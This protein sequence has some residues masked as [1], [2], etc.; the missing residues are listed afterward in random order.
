MSAFFR[1]QNGQSGFD[2]ASCATSQPRWTS[3]GS[4][5]V[6]RGPAL[7]QGS[8]P[9]APPLP[10]APPLPLGNLAA[11]TASPPHAFPS[12]RAHLW[13]RTPAGGVTV[14]DLKNLRLEVRLAPSV[15]PLLLR[16]QRL[17]GQQAGSSSSAG[18]APR[19]VAA[20]LLAQ[21][22][23]GG[24]T[25]KGLL[26]VELTA[27]NAAPGVGGAVQLPLAFGPPLPDVAVVQLASALEVAASRAP[28]PA[29]LAHLL[30]AQ[31]SCEPDGCGALT[32]HG[33]AATP[34][35]IL[36]F[37]PLL[38]KRVVPGPLVAR[39]QD[40]LLHSPPAA[41]GTADLDLE[42]GFLTMD[43]GRSLVPLAASDPTAHSMPLVG[44]WVAGSA[45]MRH[46]LVAAACLRFLCSK[47]LC[48]KATAV[49]ASFLLLLYSH[50]SATVPLCFEVHVR[51]EGGLL[52]L[53]AHRFSTAWHPEQP[54]QAA[55]CKAVACPGLALPGCP[56]ALSQR[57]PRRPGS[58]GG[59]GGD[60]SASSSTWLP[61]A[62]GGSSASSSTWL[63]GA[64]GGSSASSSTWLPGDAGAACKLQARPLQ[65]P[66][67][68]GCSMAPA[69]ALHLWHTPPGP[70]LP[71]PASFAQ[72]SPPLLVCAPGGWPDTCAAVP[73]A[74]KALGPDAAAALSAAPQDADR[75][76]ALADRQ[77]AEAAQQAAV[78]VA[79][80]T[81]AAAGSSWQAAK[82]ELGEPRPAARKD[83][84]CRSWPGPAGLPEDS[85]LA[86]AV[87]QACRRQP[88]AATDAAA[89]GPGSPVCD[90]SGTGSTPAQSPLLPPPNVPTSAPGD[91][92]MGGV[93]GD[94]S[95]ANEGD[96]PQS[97]AP[98][99]RCSLDASSL[100]S[101]AAWG[102]SSCE[103]LAPAAH[104][105]LLV[106]QQAHGPAHAGSS[107]GKVGGMP[108]PEAAVL[109]PALPASLPLIAAGWPE[110]Q[111]QAGTAQ[112]AALQQEVHLLRQE[113]ALLRAQ[114]QALQLAPA[115]TAAAALP[116]LQQQLLGAQQARPAW[117][118][119][120]ATA[121]AA[122][123]A[124]A[125]MA[126]RQQQEQEHDVGPWGSSQ[127]SLPASPLPQQ[128]GQPAGREQ[129]AGGMPPGTE[130]GA[131][132]Q[133]ALSIP[134][135][136]AQE[137]EHQLTSVLAAPAACC[138]ASSPV[139]QAAQ[140]MGADTSDLA[141][142][143]MDAEAAIDQLI[144]DAERAASVACCW[145]EQACGGGSDD[146]GNLLTCGELQAPQTLSQPPSPS[147]ELGQTQQQQQQ[148]QAAPHAQQQA[149]HTWQHAEQHGEEQASSTA[150]EAVEASASGGKPAPQLS[151]RSPV[152][153]GAWEGGGGS[154]TE[155]EELERKYGLRP[156]L[157]R[158]GSA[159][160]D[161]RRA[162]QSDDDY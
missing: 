101:L 62:A 152:H 146:G 46:P 24:S 20:S 157:R 60:S 79:A 110:A 18:S 47:A 70:V 97:A 53:Q 141:P 90:S 81:P 51:L 92:I 95:G 19:H 78:E 40:A 88:A 37:K 83:R 59:S 114:V 29:G 106:L 36:D 32:L 80:Q 156:P 4:K 54:A 68:A 121:A 150:A 25:T 139:V 5:D 31:L 2:S 127:A 3:S 145:N 76:Q 38:S 41:A 61:G 131:R 74:G 43:R 15:W 23:P 107:S 27:G 137:P 158:R 133:P 85:P 124:S 147:R 48:D 12:T 94:S 138:A 50:N 135:M 142:A 73:T 96:G 122:A 6:R 21:L 153:G 116:L 155:D 98:A 8:A 119:A 63:P 7:L 65:L 11:A 22:A 108:L 123:E 113:V 103:V 134:G 151:S 130:A 77:A 91:N 33:A 13:D 126:T 26:A 132:Q 109:G 129:P 66:G 112:V 72:P 10:P 105:S 140:A 55:A 52:P 42:D 71:G 86:Q 136:P 44:C 16:L 28:A 30:A 14:I 154:D 144:A 75:K 58:A 34:A 69:P 45:D 99:G 128:S 111:Q 115:L 57:A 148:Q 82:D 87:E 35:P 160:G 17:H 159:V 39:L 93:A 162:G 100:P 64:A 49:D 161:W 89:P 120:L 104:A 1:G 118:A 56:V 102:S 125:S 67:Q 149:Q 143:W 117:G 9:A 84:P